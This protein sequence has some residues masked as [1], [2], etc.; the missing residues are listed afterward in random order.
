MERDD[1]KIKLRKAIERHLAENKGGAMVVNPEG[2]IGRIC[3]E[4]GL[5]DAVTYNGW[6]IRRVIGKDI[7]GTPRNSKGRYGYIASKPDR[8]DYLHPP[9]AGVDAS[10][11]HCKTC[12]DL[13]DKIAAKYGQP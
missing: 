7:P 11:E 9:C 6:T 3:E 5:A 8:D 12:L 10:L 2:L 13:M 4:L 1:V